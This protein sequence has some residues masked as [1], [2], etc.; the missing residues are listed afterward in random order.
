MMKL[1]KEV[2]FENHQKVI[3]E[4]LLKPIV[5]G[6]QIRASYDHEFNEGIHLSEEEKDKRYIERIKAALNKLVDNNENSTE[7]D[8]KIQKLLLVTE[9]IR[10]EVFK[11]EDKFDVIQTNFWRN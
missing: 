6:N 4:Q 3:F 2:V 5:I 8:L 11:K 9:A 1:F 10:T 7:I